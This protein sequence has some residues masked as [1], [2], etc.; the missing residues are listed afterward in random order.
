M[1]RMT[2]ALGSE[3]RA[4][5]AAVR[6]GLA[7]HAD[8]ETAEQQQRYMKSAMPYGGLKAPLLRSVVRP[9]LAEHVLARPRAVEDHDPD[10][11]GRGGVPGGALRGPVD[12]R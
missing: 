6:D 1:V 12:R 11:V 7:A 8:V 3:G 10:A 5:V 2:A 4:L 9:L